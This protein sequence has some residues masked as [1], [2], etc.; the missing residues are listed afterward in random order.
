MN[1]QEIYN[2]DYFSGEKSF[3]YKGG[4]GK[5]VDRHFGVTYKQIVPYIYGM[6]E[7]KVLDI[8]C[9][10]GFMLERFPDFFQKF[11]IDV[12]EYAISIAKKRLPDADLKTMGAEGDLPYEENFFDMVVVNDL[13]EH[14]ENPRMALKNIYRILKKGGVLYITTPNLNLLRRIVFKY[15]DKKEHHISL[16]PRAELMHVLGSYDFKVE[17][18]WTFINMQPLIYHRFASGYGSELG[19]ICRK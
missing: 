7:G 16:F 17:E 11:G 14:L 6:N 2:K 3:F 15:P 13:L 8:G 4:Y 19:L 9:A 18:H 5:F 12:S 10:Y 1:Y